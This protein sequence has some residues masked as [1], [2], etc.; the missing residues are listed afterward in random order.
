MVRSRLVAVSIAIPALLALAA[1]GGSLDH[2]AT[3]AGSVAKSVSTNSSDVPS[4]IKGG[5]ALANSSVLVQVLEAVNPKIGTDQDDLIAKSKA[6]CT[7]VNAN[8]SESQLEADAA[9]GFTNGSWVPGDLEA[10]AI[11]GTVKAYGGC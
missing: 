10:E 8:E 5:A 2:S 9:K 11:V 4:F 3:T 1:C 6:L 7:H